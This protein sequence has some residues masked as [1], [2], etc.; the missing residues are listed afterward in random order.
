MPHDYYYR[1]MYLPQLTTGPSALSWS[2][3]GQSLVYSMAGSLW[4]QSIDSTTAEELTAGPGYDF[5]RTGRPTGST[6]VFVRYLHDA[7][8]LYTLDLATGAATQ[9]TQGG[10]VNLEPRWSPDGTRI[11][12]VST[13]GTGHFHIFI[14]TFGKSGFTATPW[15]NERKSAIARYYYSPFDQQLSPT[16][17]PDG[18]A[19]IYVDNPEIGYGSGSL[20][21]RTVDLSRAGA[22]SCIAKRRT[23][24]RRRTGRATASVSSILSYAGQPTNQ[25]WMV[26]AA[27]DDYPLPFDL[28][29]LATRRG[30]AGRR[31]RRASPSFRTRTRTPK[32]AFRTRSAA[33]GT[34]S[35]SSSEFTSRP[36]GDAGTRALPM[37]AAAPIPARALRFW[38]ATAAPMRRTMST[39]RGDDSFDRDRQDF[40]THYFHTGTGTPGSRASGGRS[41]SDGLVRRRARHRACE[42]AHR[43]EQVCPLNITMHQLDTPPEFAAW[44]SADVHV[45]MNYGGTYRTLAD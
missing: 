19:L 30:R 33:R 35:T 18:R 45:H 24:K 36:M 22:A 12:F 3:D 40:E 1:E 37:K 25:L 39:M 7:M 5:S 26:T 6:I 2:P 28:W 42:G 32:S 10:D 21:R 20:W 9:L 44:N 4:K 31:M 16:W 29:R 14:G 27:G 41:V 8:E 38:A 15:M 17:S 13:Q 23:G 34:C 43:S 11:A